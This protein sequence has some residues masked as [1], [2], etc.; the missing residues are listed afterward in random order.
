M[1][2]SSRKKRDQRR[3]Q[4]H[5]QAAKAKRRLEEQAEQV[6][7]ELLD[8]MLDAATPPHDAAALM[9]ATHGAANVATEDWGRLL[10]RKTEA[11]HVR[12]VVA[13]LDEEAAESVFAVS[14]G[15]DALASLDREAAG[16]RL[17]AALASGRY[18]AHAAELADRWTELSRPLDAL[19]AAQPLVRADP[20]DEVARQTVDA[21]LMRC[22]ERV[23]GEEWAEDRPRGQACTCG[24]G[25]T[26]EVCCGPAEEAALE[27]FADRGSLLRLVGAMQAWAAEHGFGAAIARQ[28][29]DE[30]AELPD[31]TGADV[32]DAFAALLEESAWLLP[33]EGDDAEGREPD[34]G[35]PSLLVLF[36][37]DPATDPELA[38][39]A[40]RWDA[41][42][43]F[44]LW[45]VIDT[46]ASP[47]TYLRDLVTNT[48]RFA[49]VPPEQRAVIPSWSV[50]LGAVVEVDGVW[51]MT[52][53]VVVLSPAEG[54]ALVFL[55][56]DLLE[57][58]VHSAGGTRVPPAV[59]R[60]L[61]EPPPFGRAP[62]YGVTARHGPASTPEVRRVTGAVLGSTLPR[63]VG[64]LAEHRAAGLGVRNADGDELVQLTVDVRVADLPDLLSR[65]AD[66]PDV[67]AEPDGGDALVWWGR[68]LDAIEVEQLRAEMRRQGV[69]VVD[70]EEPQRW[71]RGRFVVTAD[72]LRV[73]VNSRRRLEAALAL[74]R[75]VGGEVTVDDESSFDPALQMVLPA[76]GA[77]R[78]PQSLEVHEEWM[79]SWVDTP[80][81][82]LGGRTPRRAATDDRWVVRLETLLRGFEWEAERA[83]KV[84]GGEPLDH[85][86]LR[87]ELELPPYALL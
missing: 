73:E 1:S 46:T 70:G 86:W 69:D 76:S 33:P 15:V 37:D 14:F 59:E 41:T 55:A 20:H 12:A 60:R 78:R 13:A 27:S 40:R 11:E 61:A 82:L 45:Q 71:A 24:S 57:L 8:R 32:A 54:D 30:L 72:G 67:S 48:V 31:R 17:A 9:L 85:T 66:H 49:A 79:R 65:L 80:S 28:A 44:G 42:V 84:F 35:V 10:V 43:Q 68:Q 58:T 3:G 4:Q 19:R 25:R 16:E 51:R 47:G 36:A 39:A 87:Q 62:E 29:A 56:E 6:A 2:K 75:S 77:V 5:Q 64:E 18:D 23:V 81:P 21:A 34:D 26:W 53:D 50:L 38:T 22:H 7:H 74:L 63:L 52:R 83:A